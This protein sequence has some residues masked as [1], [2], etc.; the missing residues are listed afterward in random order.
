MAL[1]KIDHSAHVKFS[2]S[3][4][5]ESYW[6]RRRRKGEQEEKRMEEAKNADSHNHVKEKLRAKAEKEK[7]ERRAKKKMAKKKLKAKI[8]LVKAKN[9]VAAVKQMQK[10]VEDRRELERQLEWNTNVAHD[11]IKWSAEPV[12]RVSNLKPGASYVFQVRGKNYCGW[13]EWSDISPPIRT[14]GAASCRHRTAF[15]ATIGWDL[16]SKEEGSVLGYELQMFTVPEYDPNDRSFKGNPT[17]TELCDRLGIDARDIKKIQWKSVCDTIQEITYKVEGLRPASEYAFRVRTNFRDTGWSSWDESG[18]S[19]VIM[20]RPYHPEPPTQPTAVVDTETHDSLTVSWKPRRDNGRPIKL[21]S[22]WYREYDGEDDE[23]GDVPDEESNDLST[24]TLSSREVESTR[25]RITGLDYGKPYIVRVRAM[26][27]V[28]WSDPSPP[29]EPHYTN[30]TD[31][32]TRPVC[33]EW[34]DTLAKVMW[35]PPM[36]TGMPIDVYEL[37]VRRY[38][39][40][41]GIWTP[42]PWETVARLKTLVYL[43][44]NMV[45]TA[46][47]E[48]R[49]MAHTYAADIEAQWSIPSEISDMVTM[50]RRL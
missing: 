13:S 41:E 36:E 30:A 5:S 47:Y 8:S 28:G 32:P 43:V 1:P 11:R 34:H 15:S 48:F 9:A 17:S 25:Y 3:D 21:Y 26:N 49:V 33:I 16:A 45:P 6:N 27:V 39:L 20:T 46:K 18:E 31:P 24:Y 38:R 14:T 23:D 22:V 35:S 37:Q 40:E 4:G 44:Q 19:P 12:V 29:S 42:M 7:L 50:E 10:E 2:I